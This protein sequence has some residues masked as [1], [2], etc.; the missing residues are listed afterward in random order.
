M[1]NLYNSQN[2]RLSTAPSS[3]FHH[4]QVCI[5]QNSTMPAFKQMHFQCEMLS[6]E[7]VVITSKNLPDFGRHMQIEFQWWRVKCSKSPKISVLIAGSSGPLAGC[8]PG[9]CVLPRCEQRTEYPGANGGGSRAGR[10]SSS[11]LSFF[12]NIGL[13]TFLMPLPPLSTASSSHS[14]ISSAW[15]SLAQEIT[16]ASEVA[17]QL[18]SV[19]SLYSPASIWECYL[20]HS[21]LLS[22]SLLPVNSLQSYS[23]SDGAFSNSK[24]LGIISCYHP[25]TLSILMQFIFILWYFNRFN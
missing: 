24:Q 4:Y 15:W 9:V 12:F 18:L 7:L 14:F 25:Y 10:P 6:S 17:S 19:F 8:S 1:L 3:C 21:I 11:L 23:G 16:K 22:G 2:L 20:C 13:H 5:R